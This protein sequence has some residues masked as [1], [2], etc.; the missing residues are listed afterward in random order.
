MLYMYDP[1]VGFPVPAM[2]TWNT[3]ESFEKEIFRLYTCCQLALEF[4]GTTFF[5]A[6]FREFSMS[7][8]D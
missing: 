7:R 2:V 3:N 4:D 6:G 5:G 8:L 1:D